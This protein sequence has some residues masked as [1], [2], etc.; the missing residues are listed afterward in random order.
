MLLR[1]LVEGLEILEVK[2]SLDIE[3]SELAYDSRK[4]RQGALF[5]CIEG[6]TADGHHYAP[7]AINNG[8]GALLVQKEISSPDDVTVIKVKDTRYAM[9]HV[10]DR[11]FG[12]PSGRF[13]LV[14][15]TG[16]KGKTTITYMIKSILDRAGHKVGLVG[17]L[18]SMIGDEV[19][20][21]ERTT[22][23]SYDLQSL[24][25]EM[26]DKGVESVVMEV[27]SQGLE[28]HRVSCS[29][30]KIGVFTNLSQDHISKNE[31]SSMEEY[32]KAKEK[33]FRMA[34]I[35]I[36][37]I[38]SSYG[39]EIMKNAT[40]KFI[41]YGMEQ[42]A[43]IMAENIVHHQDRVVFNAVTPWG[44]MEM[45][46]SIPGKFS[47]YNALA[48]IGVS[49]ILG[50]SKETIIEGL[51]DVS[52]PGRAEVI[53][54]GG[55]YTV[56]TD[57]AHTPD[58][59][60]NILNTFKAHAT[61]RVVSVFGCGGDRDR[62]KRPLM[63]EISGRIADFTIITSD[64]PRTEEPEAIIDEIESGMKKTNGSYL[65]ITDRR[66]AI[67]YAMENAEEGDIIILA[68]KGHETYQMFKDKTIHFDE[69]EVVKEILDELK[70]GP[71]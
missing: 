17:T 20:H 69:R 58:S 9:A 61:G 47:I 39:R 22:P 19:I 12:H 33:L 8:A 30:F 25:G 62:T 56:I 1:D 68:G 40:C 57:Y 29:D 18:G 31:H 63:G 5:I 60:E 13:N 15:I 23:E 67:R 52:V 70:S 50:V 45:S 55:D 26:V 71:V 54:R 49:S 41:T 2:G 27:S 10:S 16:T 28:L 38:D 46:V 3:I 66:G 42:P 6:F 35:G 14:G 32:F 48:A 24:F 53:Y 43:D 7:F 11:I 36:V 64:N 51:A 21:T 34:E 59:L 4:V 44:R 65:R 37:N